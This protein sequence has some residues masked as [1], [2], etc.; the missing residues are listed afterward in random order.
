MGIIRLPQTVQAE[1]KSSPMMTPKDPNSTL[2]STGY[3]ITSK[4]LP[5]TCYM[6]TSYKHVKRRVFGRFKS[7]NF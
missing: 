3:V 4:L 1:A 5:D 6:K 7:G 2:I